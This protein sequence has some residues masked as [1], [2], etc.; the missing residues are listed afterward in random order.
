MVVVTR[1]RARRKSSASPKK[2][3]A[4]ASKSDE[5]ALTP[6][7]LSGKGKDKGG[8]RKV[9]G[10]G[11]P[12]RPTLRPKIRS[13]PK[14][15]SHSRSRSV[16]RSRSRSISRSP[17]RGSSKNVARKTTRLSAAFQ[18]GDDYKEWLKNYGANEAKQ[19]HGSSPHQELLSG[20][21]FLKKPS[22][23]V[24]Y[25]DIDFA[26]DE[27]ET[28]ET[29]SLFS[30][31]ED[32][33]DLLTDF[34]E[35]SGLGQEDEEYEEEG[36]EI[37]GVAVKKKRGAGG[38]PN[39]SLPSSPQRKRTKAGPGR[40]VRGISGEDRRLIHRMIHENKDPAVI[41]NAAQFRPGRR[42]RR[43]GWTPAEVM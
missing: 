42:R 22:L 17:V 29:S 21:S 39:S 41:V 38:G 16:S 26:S 9:K 7:N 40:R 8:A 37:G 6:K 36:S 19:Q 27:D 24:Q 12:K 5:K 30:G 18:S 15:Q 23:G 31:E 11:R 43:M 33:E 20:K 25:S 4:A 34:S 14:S 13:L 1:S 35:E 10:P 28:E 32:E 2:A 3:M